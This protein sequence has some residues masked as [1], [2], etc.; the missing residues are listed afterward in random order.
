MNP[1]SNIGVGFKTQVNY[2]NTRHRYPWICSLRTH[3]INPEHLCSVTLLSIPPQPTIIIGSAHCT[4][5]CK[6]RGQKVPSCC[7]ISAGVD[8]C[9]SDLAKCGQN[10]FVSEL[11]P[12]EV[13][14]VCG[15]WE[16]GPVPMAVSKEKYNVI[17]QVEDIVVHEDFDKKKGPTNGNDIAIFKVKDTE[18]RN[19]QSKKI[20][21]ICLPDHKRDQPEVGIQSGWAPP[22]PYYYIEKYF[23]SLQQHFGDLFKQFHYKMEILKSCEDPKS[24]LIYGRDLKYPS[25]TSYPAGTV[26]AKEFLRHCFSGGDSGSP[27]MVRDKKMSSRFYIDGIHS[28]SKGCE[29][30]KISF[31]KIFKVFFGV[32]Q[33]NPAVFT[34]LFC[35]LPWIAKQYK[36]SYEHESEVLADKS[37]TLPTGDL[38]DGDKNTCRESIGDLTSEERECIFPFYYE[39]EL[40]YECVLQTIDADF[41]IPNFR[42]PTRNITTKINGINSYTFKDTI[43]REYCLDKNGSLDPEIDSCDVSVRIP[44]LVPCKNNCPGGELN[45]DHS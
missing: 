23:P 28:Y 17:L 38:E 5:L 11:L 24:I 45:L 20:Y 14:I 39:G 34:K 43:L 33:E 10:A 25:N 31:E 27:L 41:I 19:A 44:P 35:Y 26:C 29:F 42:C 1:V 40:K 4:L 12:N 13:D 9:R 36:L 18:L 8:S 6:D 15:E 32:N 2:E 16:T 7:C 30:N 21:P 3:G 22:P 37:C